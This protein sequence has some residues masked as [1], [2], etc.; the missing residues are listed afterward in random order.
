MVF[1]ITKEPEF[2]DMPARCFTLPFIA[3]ECLC[4]DSPHLKKLIFEDK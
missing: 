1:M 4:S 3:T 2:N